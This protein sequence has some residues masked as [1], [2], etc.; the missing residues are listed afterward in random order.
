MATWDITTASAPLEFVTLTTYNNSCAQIDANH[1]V[2]FWRE[3]TGSDGWCQVFTVNTTT[4]A[5]TTA[6]TALEYDT[7][8][9]QENFC[10]N[11][12]SNHFLLAWRGGAATTDSWAQ[13][14][15]VNTT[16]WAITTAASTKLFDTDLGAAYNLVAIDAN[17]FL[18]IWQS[19]AGDGFTQ[20]LT[21]N[22]TTWAVTTAA[23]SL[24]IDTRNLNDTT[25]IKVDTNHFLVGWRGGTGA[26]GL[27]Q[28][29]TVDTTT[30]AITTAAASLTVDA[31]RT[32]GG[33]DLIAID[34]NHFLHSWCGTAGDGF[35]QVLTVDTTTWAV[36]TA[37]AS[38]EFDTQDG[39]YSSL[40]TI[41]T[42]HF[43]L[44]W[45]DSTGDGKSWVLEVNTTTWAVTTTT[46]APF[47]YDTQNG[48]YPSL[49]Q[50]DSS[51]FV[52][53]HV[54]GAS[55]F[56][57]ADV[58]AVELPSAA[59]FLPRGIQVNQAVKRASYF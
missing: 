36:T 41:D 11:I 12:D 58:L 16:T 59:A 6:S 28:V 9:S 33:A 14:F 49:C 13:V 30:W 25:A 34:A 46:A 54:G 19:A 22:T 57:T 44:L 4:W 45:G 42:N 15:T 35:V 2:N 1:F 37:A 56:G 55:A 23:A 17:H 27:C 26:A 48:I 3:T 8:N 24:E 32:S 31:G 7:Q 40:E 52:V 50:I 43:I 20:V 39:P 29:L 10:V 5:V 47:E 51:H 21:V 18:V 38:L 53:F